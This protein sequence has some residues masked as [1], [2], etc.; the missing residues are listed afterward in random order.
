MV[1]VL[2]AQYVWDWHGEALAGKG[3]L[4][5]SGSGAVGSR[6][7]SRMQVVGDT[8]WVMGNACLREGDTLYLPE[9]G[10]MQ[11]IVR[12]PNTAGQG[13]LGVGFLAAYD[14]LSGQ[15]LEVW[16]AHADPTQSFTLE[17]RDFA[18]GGGTF[19]LAVDLPYGGCRS[20]PGSGTLT[21][22]PGVTFGL[23]RWTPAGGL[24]GAAAVGWVNKCAF[25][26][27]YEAAT[28]QVWQVIRPSPQAT[29][30][31]FHW[32]NDETDPGLYLGLWSLVREPGVLYVSGTTRRPDIGQSTGGSFNSGTFNAAFPPRGFSEPAIPFVVRIAT[33]S[34]L[35]LTHA[36]TFYP[37]LGMMQGYGR[38]LVVKGDSLYFLLGVRRDGVAF[39]PLNAGWSGSAL[40]FATINLPSILV[41]SLPARVFLVGM[42][43]GD[44]QPLTVIATLWLQELW[45]YD[46]SSTPSPSYLYVERREDTLWVAWSDSRQTQVNGQT[47][48]PPSNQPYLMAWVGLGTASLSPLNGVGNGVLW[49][50]ASYNRV[51]GLVR[52]G[53]DVFL[54]LVPSGDMH[55]GRFRWEGSGLSSRFR[56]VLLGNPAPVWYGLAID[57]YGH[58]YGF[59]AGRSVSFRYHAVWPTAEPSSLINLPPTYGVSPVDTGRGWIGRLLWYRWQGPSETIQ[60]CAPDS[61]HREPFSYVLWGRFAAG[62]PIGG[63]WDR[64]SYDRAY[65]HR[66]RLGWAALSSG[67]RPDSLHLAVS[68]VTFPGREESGTWELWPAPLR[69]VAADATAPLD[70]VDAL[71]TAR[72]RWQVTGPSYAPLH[73]SDSAERYWVMRYVGNASASIGWR[74]ASQNGPFYRLS[75]KIDGSS[76]AFAYVPYDPTLGGEALYVAV[77][78]T[79]SVLLYRLRFAD[80]QVERVRGWKIGG[81]GLFTP[82]EEVSAPISSLVYNSYRGVLLAVE[83]NTRIRVV[84]L[85]LVPEV[86]AFVP[87]T[88]YMTEGGS[89]SRPYLVAAGREGRLW[90]GGLTRMSMSDYPFL[91]EEYSTSTAFGPYLWASNSDPVSGC[92]PLFS[93][94]EISSV[95]AI[96]PVPVGNTLAYFIDVGHNSSGCSPPVY[97]LLRAVTP[98]GL[99]TVDTLWRMFTGLNALDDVRFAMVWRADPAPH[100]LM[101]LPSV[102][103]SSQSDRYILRYWLDGRSQPRDTLIGPVPYAYCSYGLDRQ[104]DMFWAALHNLEVT[105]GGMILFSTIGGGGQ[106]EIL[107]AVPLY[108]QRPLMRDTAFYG[109]PM[110]LSALSTPG[111]DVAAG[112]QGSRRVFFSVDSLRA[113]RDS[114]WW[115]AEVCPGSSQGVRTFLSA[116]YV[117]PAFVTTVS[118]P[119]RVCHGQLFHAAVGYGGDEFFLAYQRAYAMGEVCGLAGLMRRFDM[120]VS[121]PGRA[122][123]LLQRMN[124]YNVLPAVPFG[125]RF[126]AVDSCA[127]C[128]VRLGVRGMTTVS[129]SAFWRAF[130]GGT[131]WERQLAIW[132][133][134]QLQVRLLLE[135]PSTRRSSASYMDPHPLFTRENLLRAASFGSG[136]LQDSL[137]LLPTPWSD[138]SFVWDRIGGETYEDDTLSFWNSLRWREPFWVSPCRVELREAPGGPV[139]DR[140]WGLVDT[141]GWVWVWN[142]PLVDSTDNLWHPDRSYYRGRLLSFCACDTTTA[143]WLVVR[144]PHHLPLRSA[145]PL[146]LGA[147]LLSTD[148]AAPAQVDLTDPSWLDGIPGEH[149]TFVPDPALP[150]GLRAA[151]WGGNCDDA[152]QS[153]FYPGQTPPD[154][155]RI[156]AADY[157]FLLHRNG[158]TGPT[159]TPADVD[160]DGAVTAADFVIVIQNMNA[161]RQGVTE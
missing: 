107:A 33:G 38:A 80:G 159:F 62:D 108:V 69:W 145:G 3:E 85:G 8:L 116:V 71:D 49:Q 53:P 67:N 78:Y 36:T 44:L 120:E 32:E 105:R 9:G 119:S 5:P 23:Y 103:S 35:T 132:R 90:I 99:I 10:G 96:A 24:G 43:K 58:L 151:A 21:I 92:E 57:R 45:A 136:P 161:L 83:G 152:F 14:R 115:Q 40:P 150:G 52:Y 156:N 42:R 112:M 48:S 6:L 142:P 140:A 141:S 121:P 25:D 95:R 147:G 137:W 27:H 7:Y 135:G 31:C 101:T 102:N 138:Q 143:K 109:S 28:A 89:S 73:R 111:R 100:L 30:L 68:E 15:L 12:N 126:A 97:G 1:Q 65:W 118:A 94:S 133:G 117:L 131:S 104:V 160:A 124:A 153:S 37:T 74:Q 157:E 148:P 134:Y 41:G 158:V 129:D 54:A 11:A 66:Y 50:S 13:Y 47:Y 29:N 98:T 60:R 55:L 76:H 88:T 75:A 110:D 79:D 154:Y 113:G 86:G 155:S 4:V 114:V 146:S 26:L 77:N 128:R 61:V 18:V 34:S 122:S 72:V 2:L 125:A 123:R 106:D 17:F 144:T 59:G 64:M 22:D 81:S 19:W 16:Y 70:S 93:P 20:R 51:V 39:T 46:G 82:R 87:P 127:Q 149:Y 56:S 63:V 84:P 130:L 139:V 91:G